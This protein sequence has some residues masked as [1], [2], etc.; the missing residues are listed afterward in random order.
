[1]ND[2]Y[3]ESDNDAIMTTKDKTV[4]TLQLSTV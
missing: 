2:I 1:M 4:G 3:N